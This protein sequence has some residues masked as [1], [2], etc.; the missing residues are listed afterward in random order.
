MASM[1]MKTTVRRD[2]FKS[3]WNKYSDSPDN[4]AMMLNQNAEEL[5]SSDR[6]D[7][8]SSLPDLTDKD[9]VDIGAGIGRFTTIL[10]QTAKSVLSTD[11]IESFI[12]KNRE[13]NS[14]LENVSY[15]VG[16]AVNLVLDNNSVDLVFTNW[17]MMYLSDNE[18]LEFLNNA[19]RWLR[20]NGYL[21]LRESCSEPSTGRSKSTMHSTTDANPTSYRFSSLY[22]KLLRTIRFQCSEGKLWRFEVLWSASVPTYVQRQS[23]WRQVH[24]LT[25]KV[26]A[27]ENDWVPTTRELHQLFSLEWNRIQTH[28]DSLLDN[29]RRC[30]TDQIFGRVMTSEFVPKNSTVFSYN[31]RRSAFHVHIN[32]HLLSEKFTCNVWNV[33]TNEYYY[34]TSLTKANEIKDQR[35]RFGW[36][37]T[38]QSAIDYWREREGIFN[39]FVA[40]ELLTTVDDETLSNLTVILKPEAK[41]ITLEPLDEQVTFDDLRK[42]V[43]QAGWRSVNMTNVTEPAKELQ[44]DYFKDHSLLNEAIVATGKWVLIEAT[45]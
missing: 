41:I 7:I 23:N 12:L 32:A 35:V 26:P 30:W 18:V 21:H 10:A 2:V 24:W 29:E 6:N 15:K 20:P 19:I 43:S 3:F 31:P 37:R 22:I 34:R 11:F 45:L 25:R 14:H 17:L 39:A 1:E 38:L 27:D 44:K 40:T 13:R 36:N 33:E 9:A 4:N 28:W 16:D 8:L 5:E 42:R